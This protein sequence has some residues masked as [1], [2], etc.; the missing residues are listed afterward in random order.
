ME[1]AHGLTDDY[2]I[3]YQIKKEMGHVKLKMWEPPVAA[4]THGQT[5]Q[6]YLYAI[7]YSFARLGEAEAFLRQHL[8]I[9]GAL[10][11]PNTGFPAEGE[12]AILPFPTWNMDAESSVVSAH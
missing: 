6:P 4:A 3:C 10:D 8:L 2:V 9:N 5:E 7:N 1:I 11:V 12:V